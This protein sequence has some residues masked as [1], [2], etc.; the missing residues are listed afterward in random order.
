MTNSVKCDTAHKQHGDLKSTV[1][2]VRSFKQNPF[3]IK[4]TKH[5]YISSFQ[6][7]I[8][9]I[10]LLQTCPYSVVF[11]KEVHTQKKMVNYQTYNFV[12]WVVH[13]TASVV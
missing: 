3:T 5:R 7:Q 1:T 13:P 4:D 9:Q 8:K 6:V 2:I 12:T 11:V 10:V